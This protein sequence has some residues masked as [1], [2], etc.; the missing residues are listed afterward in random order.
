[1]PFLEIS[2][3]SIIPD[4]SAYLSHSHHSKG[5]FIIS[6]A[7]GNCM[8]QFTLFSPSTLFYFGGEILSESCIESFLFYLTSKSSRDININ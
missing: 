1:M 2:G 3:S 7:E 6:L 4:L 8:M 5:Y